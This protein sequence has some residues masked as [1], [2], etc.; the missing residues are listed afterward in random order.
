MQL[1][2]LLIYVRP[3]VVSTGSGDLSIN[4]QKRMILTA[5]CMNDRSFRRGD[6]PLF[7]SGG[8]S[9]AANAR[10]KKESGLAWAQTSS[11]LQAV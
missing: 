2:I 11:L 5:V 9:D 8:I 4:P 7:C 3:V 1:P 10:S 6:A